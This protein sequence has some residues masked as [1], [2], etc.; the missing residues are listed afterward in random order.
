MILAIWCQPGKSFKINRI[1]SCQKI[2]TKKV[3]GIHFL[4]IQINNTSHLTKMKKEKIK[5]IG[6]KNNTNHIIIKTQ[7]IEDTYLTLEYDVK[8][9]ITTFDTTLTDVINIGKKIN[10]YPDTNNYAIDMV[11]LKL[12]AINS[13]VF[14]T[15]IIEKNILGQY[16]FIVDSLSKG[17]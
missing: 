8:N 6:G 7:N 17:I 2:T 11:S 1:N 5:V 14:T 12:K 13:P 10:I 3:I 15:K 16:Y 4:K 9:I